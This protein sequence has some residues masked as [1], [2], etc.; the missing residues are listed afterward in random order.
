MLRVYGARYRK[1][2]LENQRQRR[3]EVQVTLVFPTQRFKE[4]LG[5]AKGKEEIDVYMPTARG[6]PSYSILAI[7]QHRLSIPQKAEIFEP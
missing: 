4:G 7:A 1:R 2:E 3:T 6:R 5:G